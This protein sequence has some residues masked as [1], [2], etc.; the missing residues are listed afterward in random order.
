MTRPPLCLAS[1]AALALGCGPIL[2]TMTPA[3][4]TPHH[5]VRAA[6][7]FGASVPAGQIVDAIDTVV[8]LAG[9]VS[10][11]EALTPAEQN[12]LASQAVGL[13]FS[14]PTLSYEFQARYGFLP[15]WDA[16]L[17]LV[18]SNVRADARFQVLSTE[19][20]AP[21]DLSVGAGL[22]LGLTGLSLG[23]VVESVISVDDYRVFTV[24]VPVLAGWSGRFG[25]LWFGPKVVA[26]FHGTGM[27]V[28]VSSAETRVLD[29]SGT[30]FH[31]GA[32]VGGAVGYRWVWVAFELSVLGMNGSASITFPGGSYA[33][34]FGG[35]VVAPSFALLIQI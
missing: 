32:L 31:Y 4:V 28:R 12:T 14:P 20:G 1:A 27:S 3:Q 22:G 25:H 2:S 17:R 8:T 13:V 10:R 6:G 18:G 5:S 23:S 30:T 9:R 19:R 24:D 15:R 35:V 33:P 29:V 21:L 7:G 26:G 16:G 34:T 11:N